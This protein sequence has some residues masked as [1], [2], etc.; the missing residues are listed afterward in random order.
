MEKISW[1]DKKIA[2]DKK[3]LTGEEID[4]NLESN[5]IKNVVKNNEIKARELLFAFP[6]IDKKV[7]SFFENNTQK[8]GSINISNIELK[9]SFFKK[10]G[11]CFK[12]REIT[13]TRGYNYICGLDQALTSIQ[14][15]NKHKEI[16][17]FI[18]KEL[19]NTQS[20]KIEKILLLDYLKNSIIT[21]LNSFLYQEKLGLQNLDQSNE[22]EKIR[23]SLI[24]NSEDIV[25]N[26]LDLVLNKE[27]NILSGLNFDDILNTTNQASDKLLNYH[28]KHKFPSFYVSRPEATNPLT[29]VGASL[30]CAE[31]YKNVDAIIGVP[32]GGTEFAITTK[33]LI[34]N[35]RGDDVK[36][37]LLPISLHTL[38]KF[39]DKK[40]DNI[41]I[42]RNIKKYLSEK[43]SSILICDDNTSTG[44]TLQLLKNF[45]S[46]T[47][48][49]IKIY[50]TV[51]EADIIRSH[52]D[53]YNNKRTH[54]ANKNIYADSVNI[55][56]VSRRIKPK[57]EL[58]E[59]VES[60]KI[61]NY[62]KNMKEKS[63]NLIDKIYANVMTSVNEKGVDYSSFTEKNAVL[64]FYNTFLS[65]FYITPVELN[66]KI[67]PSVEHAYQAAKFLSLDWN[68]VPDEAKREIEELLKSRECVI[69]II[70]N[71]EL[72]L[73]S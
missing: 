42:E 65:N 37:I 49:N 40:N 32:S 64:E 33:V 3:I 23:A 62:Y 38:E 21:I 15:I 7:V 20:N 71:N 24:K 50:C 69:P 36:L 54:I 14:K 58:K 46:T 22:Y 1:N 11:M 6:N 12:N 27:L 63:D 35:K 18:T 59:L 47:H 17:E 67:Y 60:R 43:I 61:I 66:E 52:I 30:I 26:S 57:V 4:N 56:P 19:S 10:E 28:H 16:I 34:S 73:D 53:K 51:A 25:K 55:L 44:R 41:G 70:Y 5:E 39:S 8:D 45:I 48:N 13:T 9:S 68:S 31:K 2:L 72:F 29:I